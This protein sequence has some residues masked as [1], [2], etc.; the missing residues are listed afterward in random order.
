MIP[1]SRQFISQKDK[2]NVFKALGSN[3]LTTGPLVEKF[4]KKL[5]ERFKAKYTVAVNSATSGLH[6][7]SLALGLKKNNYLWTSPVSFVASSNCALY[8]G[9]KV[10][11]V[12]IDDDDYNLSIE[13]LKL[14]L[15]KI[16][17]KN[18]LPKIIVPV[19]LAGNPVNLKKLKEL[20]K[21]FKFKILE[22]AS[23]ASGSKFNKSEIGS[24]KYS[25]ITVFSFHPVKTFTTGEGGAILTSSKKIY[26]KLILLRNQGIT[27]DFN[28]NKS[29][30][31][32]HYDVIEL[33][34]NYRLTDIQCAL[35]ISQLKVLNNF[36]KTRNKIAN[37]YKKNLSNKINFQEVKP[38]NLS[39]YHLFI[40]RVPAKLRDKIVDKLYK[41]NI[42]TPLH[43]IPIYK[44]K[45]YRKYNYKQKDF[46]NSEKYSKEA[47]S[48][49]I[50]YTLKI[51]TQKKI[52]KIINSFF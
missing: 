8:C 5:S 49:P 9:G 22:D 46:P 15:E 36:L 24:C 43:Y 32:S 30:K 1:Y 34:F 12:D 35:G 51:S 38:S 10:D 23:H 27:R 45:I 33:G 6:I 29:N 31:Q 40:I 39:T 7:A 13:K 50:Y 14:K 41:N 37:F 17:L 20:S 18:K 48:I 26:E 3:F 21:K 28:F 11:F 4:E 19:H 47:I 42:R 25:D 16:K 44:H 52:I 2:L